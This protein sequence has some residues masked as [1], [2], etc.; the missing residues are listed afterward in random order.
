MLF[1]FLGFIH[2]FPEH[3][4]LVLLSPTGVTKMR[5]CYRFSKVKVLKEGFGFTVS[6]IMEV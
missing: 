4:N 1:V 6:F 3:V 5:V 2:L